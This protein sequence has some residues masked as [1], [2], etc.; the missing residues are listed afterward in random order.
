MLSC[1]N[2]MPFIE[3]FFQVTSRMLHGVKGH[4]SYRFWQN[5]NHVYFYFCF[6]RWT[7]SSL[8]QWWKTTTTIKLKLEVFQNKCSISSIDRA[9]QAWCWQSLG[10]V[11]RMP[12]NFLSTTALQWTPKGNRNRGRPET[13]RRSRKK[14]WGLTLKTGTKA[15]AEPDGD[16]S[17]SIHAPD[18]TERA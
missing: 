14:N 3:H 1:A 12:S 15:A 11:C 2:H 9:I 10:Y 5:W 16:P 17:M 18:S 7:S 13:T 8:N 4:L 6:T